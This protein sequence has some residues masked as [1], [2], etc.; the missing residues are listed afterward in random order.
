MAW[1]QAHLFLLGEQ[2][3]CCTYARVN[4]SAVLAKASSRGVRM[5]LRLYGPPRLGRRSWIVRHQHEH[6]LG[7]GWR[8]LRRR[9]GRRGRRRREAAAAAGGG[10]GRHPPC[11]HTR[12]VPTRG[13]CVR[14]QRPAL[15]VTAVQPPPGRIVPQRGLGPGTNTNSQHSALRY[16]APQQPAAAGT[17]SRC[18][19]TVAVSGL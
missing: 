14:P 15:H 6:A 13:R 1:R 9:R 17:G 11:D 7:S 12:D 3:V 4:V 2:T 16:A 10:G 18:R 19:S 5:M 8:R